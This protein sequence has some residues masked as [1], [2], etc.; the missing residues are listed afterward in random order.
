MVSLRCL[1]V[2]LASVAAPSKAMRWCV[3]VDCFRAF[4]TEDR[5]MDVGLLPV[6][7]TIGVLVGILLVGVVLFRIR[8]SAAS[9]PSDAGPSLEY[10]DFAPDTPVTAD[11]TENDLFYLHAQSRS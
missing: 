3:V 6:R 7:T 5:G 1:P 9:G 4:A 11:L 8:C 10:T 2:P